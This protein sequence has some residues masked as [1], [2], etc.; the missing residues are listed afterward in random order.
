M[1]EFH[2]CS[3]LGKSHLSIEVLQRYK[4]LNPLGMS[5]HRHRLAHM[6]LALGD[7]SPYPANVSIGI[8]GW[9]SP[10]GGM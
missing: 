1:L 9:S 3:I 2:F 8:I 7:L 6:K 10:G 5:R 4:F